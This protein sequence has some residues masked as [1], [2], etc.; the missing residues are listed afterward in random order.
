[1]LRRYSFRLNRDIVKYATAVGPTVVVVG[2]ALGVDFVFG[3]SLPLCVLLGGSELLR[4]LL[5][6]LA[7]I[8]REYG[9]SR[10]WRLQFI[11]SDYLPR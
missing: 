8:R 10:R 5:H 2:S 4:L 1:M 6:R 7:R 9:L 3:G 11:K